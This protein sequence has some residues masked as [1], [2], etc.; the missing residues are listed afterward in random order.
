MLSAP[1]AD[2]IRANVGTAQTRAVGPCRADEAV[3]TAHV[4][5]AQHEERHRNGDEDDVSLN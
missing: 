4:Q 2:Q 1:I 5:Q 3:E